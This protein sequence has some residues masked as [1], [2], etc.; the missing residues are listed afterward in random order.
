MV[1]KTV[2]RKKRP[3]G[4]PEYVI[5]LGKFSQSA[6]LGSREGG[7]RKICWLSLREVD[8]NQTI[9]TKRAIAPRMSKM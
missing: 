1:I 9:G 5:E 3:K 7:H 6:G 8:N 4:K 2:L